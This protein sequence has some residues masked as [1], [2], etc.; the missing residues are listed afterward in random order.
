MKKL[1]LF[2]VLGLSGCA[3]SPV[4]TTAPMQKPIV[5]LAPDVFNQLDNGGAISVAR[6]TG[7][8]SSKC[9]LRLYLDAKPIADMQPG[10]TA[11][12][13]ASPGKHM[14]ATGPSPESN[15]LCRSAAESMRREVSVDVTAGQTARFRQAI[16]ANGEP[17][18]MPTAF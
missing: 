14:L 2:A 9:R 17:S 10:E 18:L 16:S 11:L 5:I 4:P 15:V 6:D 13:Y 12:F 1:L 8:V 7:W 3:T